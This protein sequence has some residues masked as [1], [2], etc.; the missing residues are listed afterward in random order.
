MAPASQYTPSIRCKSTTSQSSGDVGLLPPLLVQ[1]WGRLPKAIEEE[2]R[3]ITIDVVSDFF[4]P[5]QDRLDPSI[6]ETVSRGQVIDFALPL[7]RDAVGISEEMMN[8]TRLYH[9]PYP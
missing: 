3:A 2:T 4:E 6:V 5:W 8:S 9:K 7:P 1:L